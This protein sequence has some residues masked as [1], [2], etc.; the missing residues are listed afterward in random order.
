MKAKELVVIPRTEYAFLMRLKKERI[1]EVT[2]TAK[3]KKAIQESEKE[4]RSGRYLT[5]DELERN[6]ARPHSK[7]RS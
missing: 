5:L 6:V 2:L 3:Q 4:L 1:R 7:A